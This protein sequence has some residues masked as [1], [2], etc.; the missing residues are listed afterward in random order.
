MLHPESGHN[1]VYAKIRLRRRFATNRSKRNSTQKRRATDLQKL[2]ANLKLREEILWVTLDKLG[3]MN[4][5]ANAN[6]MAENLAEIMLSAAADVTP[7]K[8]IQ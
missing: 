5:V 3:S 4:T 6:D 7:R 8:K 1:L 2:T